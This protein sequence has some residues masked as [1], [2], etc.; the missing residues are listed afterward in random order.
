MSVWNA[1][2]L[3]VM[4]EFFKSYPLSV[5]LVLHDITASDTVCTCMCVHAHV[6][7]FQIYKTVQTL[8]SGTATGDTVKETVMCVCVC[9]CQ[10]GI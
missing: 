1:T 9:V 5:I 2:D 10:I 7:A 6:N 8:L 4:I 3:I